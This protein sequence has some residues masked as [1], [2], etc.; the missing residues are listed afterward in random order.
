MGTLAYMPPEQMRGQA[1]TP[2]SD[3]FSVGVVLYRLLTGVFPFKKYEQLSDRAA[4]AS[5]RVDAIPAA[6]DNLIHALLDPDPGQRPGARELLDAFAAPGRSVVA[7]T[8]PRTARF[9]GR[10]KELA[11]LDRH[12]QTVLGGTPVVARI[13]GE[14]G[15]G[16]TALMRS[17]SERLSREKHIPVLVG[18]CHPHVTVPFRGII[19]WWTS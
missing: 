3:W 6:L 12:L 1:A 18:R 7:V 11:T 2:A 17:F 4:R 10:R 8:P 16:K 9:V 15:I 13:R 14:S 5:T 19:R